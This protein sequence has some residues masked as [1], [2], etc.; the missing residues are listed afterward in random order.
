MKTKVILSN[1]MSEQQNQPVRLYQTRSDQNRWR[2]QV[3]GWQLIGLLPRWSG[4]ANQRAAISGSEREASLP[5][6]AKRKQLVM[7]A[8]CLTSL[9]PVSG[10]TLR[11]PP[12]RQSEHSSSQSG[13]VEICLWTPA[14]ARSYRWW[15]NRPDV[16]MTTLLSFCV[17]N[18][19]RNP[20][21]LW[22]G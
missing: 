4:T 7:K 2:L 14:E 10:E 8:W 11:F 20:P 17:I 3:R 12:D 15:W 6:G 1:F 18:R 13:H 19:N 5:E 22:S 21:W 16:V 9:P